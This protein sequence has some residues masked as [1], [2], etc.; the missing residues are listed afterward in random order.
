L[1]E[2]ALRREVLDELERYT[3]RYCGVEADL[4]RKHLTVAPLEASFDASAIT[5][6]AA[7]AL[8]APPDI[9]RVAARTVG[10]VEAAVSVMR[11]LTTEPG[12]GAVARTEGLPLALNAADALYSLAHLSLGELV[13]I[14]IQD[15]VRIV[16]RAN[17]LSSALWEASLQGGEP[18]GDWDQVEG[19]LS[20]LAGEMAAHAAGRP[21][22]RTALGQ[23]FATS[24]QASLSEQDFDEGERRRL[25]ALL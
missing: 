16:G 21:T 14:E 19:G 4:V 8:G 18:Y 22:S 9:A 2:V 11:C 12:G 25:K 10:F 1:V 13:T 15:R 7:T 24:G 17:E 5:L 20:R 3:A 6:S 23:F